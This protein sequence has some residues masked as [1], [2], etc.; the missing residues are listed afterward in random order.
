MC[1]TFMVEAFLGGRRV[2]S[3]QPKA[4]GT[5]YCILS[6]LELIPRV[7][8]SGQ[9]ADAMAV[10]KPG[11]RGFAQRFERSRAR[12]AEAFAAFAA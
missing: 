4:K 10:T 11:P 6:R 7:T 12:V 8:A 1:S 5:D 9:F 2:I 3:V